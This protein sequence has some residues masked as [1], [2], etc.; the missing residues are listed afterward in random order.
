MK[1]RL[2]LK[3]LFISELTLSPDLPNSCVLKSAA[4]FVGSWVLR[5]ARSVSINAV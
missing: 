1:G 4:D 2:S 3:K 5:A